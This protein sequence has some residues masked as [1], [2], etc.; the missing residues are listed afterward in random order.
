MELVEKVV[1]CK[2]GYGGNWGKQFHQQDRAYDRKF[3]AST[4]NASGNNG[5][6]IKKWMKSE[7]NK[8]PRME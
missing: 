4:I 8:L 6:I 5:G 2:G 1:V 7:L 3:I